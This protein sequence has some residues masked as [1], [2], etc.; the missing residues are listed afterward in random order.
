MNMLRITGCGFVVIQ[1]EAVEMITGELRP[2]APTALV[3]PPR[4]I[5][6][7]P[8]VQYA[9][10]LASQPFPNSPNFLSQSCWKVAPSIHPDAPSVHPNFPE[11]LGYCYRD[12]RWDHDGG[13]QGPVLGCSD[14]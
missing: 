14:G 10:L 6:G 11:A 13:Y 7:C 3:A 9:S 8:G 1:I 12:A 2:R 5:G 4:V